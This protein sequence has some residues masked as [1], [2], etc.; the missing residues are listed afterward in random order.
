MTDIDT[1]REKIIAQ[2]T[3]MWAL[4]DTGHRVE[5]FQEVEACGNTINQELDLGYSPEL[6]LYV[7]Y[8]HDLFAW[9]RKNHHLLSAEFMKGT[10]HPLITRL[11]LAN[12]VA[13]AT[14]CAEHRASFRGR[15]S[16]EFSMLMNSADRGFPGN[17]EAMLER[18]IQ[19]R[20]GKGSSR[21]AALTPSIEHLKEKYGS[22]GY[23]QYP[24][25][26]KRCFKEALNQQRFV[27]DNL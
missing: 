25:L 7:A 26:Y 5:H 12:R 16:T 20:I 2:F 23:A 6:I 4:N 22:Q 19:Y 13:I 27:I 17:V 24:E 15:F 14:A 8:F 11:S 10:D 21:K 3:P 18:A 1:L 9:S